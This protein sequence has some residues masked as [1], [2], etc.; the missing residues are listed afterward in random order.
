MELKSLKCS[1]CGGL[2]RQIGDGKYICG[3]CGTSFM[4]DYDKEDVEYQKIKVDAELKKKEMEMAERRMEVF[5]NTTQNVGKKVRTIA[6]VMISIFVCMTFISIFAGISR[7]MD[8]QKSHGSNE[9]WKAQSESR[10]KALLE[11]AERIKE[12]QERAAEESRQAMLAAYKVTPENLMADEFFMK[13]ATAA[14][15]S[16]I[17]NNTHLYWT[18]WVWN[19]E[20]IYVT[21]FLL[22]AKDDNAWD[23]NILVNVYKV[24]W[25]KEYES[26]TNK[27]VMYDA[28]CLKNVSLNDDGTIK[29]DYAADG[30]SYHNEIVE[31]QFLSGYADYD[32]LIREEIYGNT[33]YTYV[34]FQFPAEYVTNP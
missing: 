16:E 29:T 22:T 12:S 20:P 4:A 10:S 1:K 24:F 18:N 9:D 2:L 30:L 15:K 27:Y 19:E 32:Q 25:D 14:M 26:H 31:N 5:Q 21:S 23:H 28:T 3:S 6:I 34:E 13:N 33:D 11:E 8:M 17:K 7:M